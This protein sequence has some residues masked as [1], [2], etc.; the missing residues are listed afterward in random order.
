MTF[1][2]KRALKLI[3]EIISPFT[4]MPESDGQAPQ[5][6][7]RMPSW[8]G[9]TKRLILRHSALLDENTLAGKLLSEAF[10]LVTLS[11]TNSIGQE[12]RCEKPPLFTA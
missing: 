4:I 1:P 9:R 10:E 5:S 12:Q 3:I 11:E 2:S 8:L 7:T 6:P